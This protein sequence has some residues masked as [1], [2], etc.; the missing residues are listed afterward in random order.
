MSYRLALPPGVVTTRRV[1]RGPGF[2]GFG[3]DLAALT[4][5][6]PGNPFAVPLQSGSAAQRA[7]TFAAPADCGPGMTREP[8][9][10]QCL[11]TG[12]DPTKCPPGMKYTPGQGCVFYPQAGGCPAGTQSDPLGVSCWPTDVPGAQPAPP[13]SGGGCPTGY[14]KD[15]VLGTSCLPTFWQVPGAVAGQGLPSA[16]G[17]YLGQVKDAAG[18]CVFP[19]CFPGQT[20]NVTTGACEPSDSSGGY[21]VVRSACDLLPVGLR[22]PGCPAPTPGAGGPSTTI[23]ANIAMLCG[24]V[25][26]GWPV[27]PGCGVLPDGTIV[28]KDTPGG[29]TG[30]VTTTSSDG[31]GL[32]AAVLA[33]GAVGLVVGGVVLYQKR[34]KGKR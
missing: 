23:G 29:T 32:G 34:K 22:P 20:F 10:G 12:T 28:P 21:D 5:F 27:P 24:L 8:I 6:L 3:A 7:A 15:P 17:C 9:L 2:R 4:P 18:N 16:P 11:P 26:K 31:F 30:T 25:P 13:T 19:F 33:L 1:P 14:V